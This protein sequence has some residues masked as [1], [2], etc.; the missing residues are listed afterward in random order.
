MTYKKVILFAVGVAIFSAAMLVIPFTI[1]TS[2]S[3]VGTYLES[4]ILFALIII[5][6]CKKPLEAGL[7]T[8]LFFL[9]SQPLIY[10][11]QV[12]FSSLGWQIFMFYPQWFYITLATFPGAMIAF[13]VKKDNLLSGVNKLPKFKMIYRD[14]KSFFVSENLMPNLTNDNYYKNFY[15]TKIKIFQPNR[16]SSSLIFLAHQHQNNFFIFKF[17]RKN[18]Y[19]FIKNNNSVLY[20]KI[21]LANDCVL[22]EVNYLDENFFEFITS[23][24]ENQVE[25]HVFS[26][27]NSCSLDN[28]NNLRAPLGN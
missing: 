7:K 8:F 23:N 14:D 18:S 2:L 21:S 3:N 20:C 15:K 10:L 1:H 9:I 12:P 5:M 22:C 17:I 19:N 27:N 16:S 26:V 6:N 11:L 25:Y 13:Y 24:A 28:N 4:W